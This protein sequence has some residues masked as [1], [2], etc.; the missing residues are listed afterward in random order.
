MEEQKSLLDPNKRRKRIWILLIILVLIWFPV[1]LYIVKGVDR[2]LFIFKGECSSLS[3]ELCRKSIWCYVT[4]V[5]M[6][7]N[8]HGAC[9]DAFMQKC[10]S[11]W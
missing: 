3:N 11:K 8:E 2:S 6:P 10:V 4:Q 7:C 1:Y 9:P 5:P